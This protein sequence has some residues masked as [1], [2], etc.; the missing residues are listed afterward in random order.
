MNVSLEL[1]TF[2]DRKRNEMFRN[3]IINLTEQHWLGNQSLHS[4]ANCS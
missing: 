1:N 2:H 4:N 3:K